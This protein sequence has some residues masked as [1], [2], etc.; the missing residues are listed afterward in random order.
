MKTIRP[1]C[2]VYSL[3]VKKYMAKSHQK[4]VPHG[5]LGGRSTANTKCPR[6]FCYHCHH[7][8]GIEVSCPHSLSGLPCCCQK[9]G[10]LGE[11]TECQSKN[12]LRT[13]QE[14]KAACS[15]TPPAPRFSP[16]GLVAADTLPRAT[17]AVQVSATI[18]ARA[19]ADFDL[20]AY[21]RG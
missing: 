15:A 10:H 11:N 7:G 17:Q 18:T 19:S 13:K 16:P 2:Q 3:W 1:A 21:F 20:P 14:A 8:Y 4:A 6:H 12:T 9:P 5:S